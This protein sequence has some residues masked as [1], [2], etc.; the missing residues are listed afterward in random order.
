M[1]PWQTLPIKHLSAFSVM[2][3]SLTELDC[4]CQSYLLAAL[5]QKWKELRNVRLP[6]G[7]KEGL[8]SAPMCLDGVPF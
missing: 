6:G 2:N 3:E 7:P 5:H 1:P 8:P 4:L